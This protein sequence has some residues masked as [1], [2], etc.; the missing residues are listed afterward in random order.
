MRADLDR[1]M[2]ARGLQA[3]IVTGGEFHNTL[4]A[5]LSNGIDIHNGVVVKKR[6]AAPVLFVGGMELEEAA[7]SG[8]AVRNF[9][10][11]GYA[12]MLKRAEGDGAKAGVELFG[13]FI[14][15]FAI[16]SGKIGIYGVGELHVWLERTRMLT[17]AFPDY[18][19]VGETGMTLFDD[20]W[21]TKD[22]QEIG[23]I[24]QVAATTNEIIQATWDFLSGYRAQG[25]AVVKHDGSPLTIGDV[26]R[27]VRRETMDRGLEDTGMIFAQGYEATFPH[28]RGTESVALKV[29]EPIIF[30]F[31][32]RQLGGGYYHDS[33]RTWCLGHAPE[34]VCEIWQQVSEAFDIAVSAC[35]G[36]GTKCHTLQEAVQDYFERK[37]HQ[38]Q[39]T[40]PG[41]KVG[42]VHGLGHGVGLNIHERP[43]MSH[44]MRDDVLQAGNVITIE[45]GLYYPEKRIG[46]RLED[47]FVIDTEGKLVSLTPF[48]KDLLVP[49]RG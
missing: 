40:H 22:A 14:E 44:L 34:A 19:F 21:Q 36:P 11:L 38:T 32:P 24:S 18:Q 12:E 49:L 28:S 8:I 47:T 33:T 37:G 10:D 17:A 1:L 31:F 27:F 46:V 6:G 43:S 20:A 29:G 45:P 48:K 39:R 2:E 4:R 9:A 15:T 16:P 3:V 30:D 41:T 5:Y 23:I 35:K 7:K 25:D 13:K 42:Y 26:K